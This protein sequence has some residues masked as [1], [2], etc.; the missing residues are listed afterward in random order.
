MIDVSKLWDAANNLRANSSLTAQ[1]YSRP[2]LGLL[3]LKFADHKYSNVEAEISNSLPANIQKLEYQ[4]KGVMY[5]PEES[6]YKYLINLPEGSDIGNKV[7]DAMR[8]IEQQN[9]DLKGILPKSYNKFESKMLFELLKT[10]NSIPMDVEGDVFGKI[11]EYFLG[12]FAM[13]EGQK[14]GD[15]F[16]PTS[17]VK[18]IVNI[19]EP[20]SGR[21]YDPACG[22]GGMFVQSANFV[23]RHQ[24]DI[25]D[26]SIFGQ[27]L[28][29][30]HVRIAKMNLAIHQLSGDVKQGNTYYDDEHQSLN[31]FDYV[32][33]NPPFNVS[34]VDKDRIKDDP[35]YKLGIP[36]ANNANYLWIQNF[37]TA[38]NEKGRAGFVIANSASDAGTSELEIRKKLLETGDVDIIIS[39]SSNFFYTVILPVTLWFFN[40][41]KSEQNNDKVLFID[42]REIYHQ[43]DRAHRDF[44]PEQLEFLA[45]IVRLYREGDIETT[46]GS[47]ELLNKHFSDNKYE[48]IKGLCK[49]ATLE[50]IKEQGYSLNPGRYVGVAEEEDD[51]VDFHERLGELNQE[52]D[53]LNEENRQFEKQIAKN[54]D[55]IINE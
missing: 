1:E 5:L 11:Y 39:I 44:K 20:Y 54:I 21:I 9:E 47:K 18:L 48:D 22:S 41:R 55:K 35:R 23:E 16:T 29:E 6:R 28:A 27:T 52:L 10:F 36:K 7:N 3:F 31:R 25:N 50:E 33:A 45:N 38:L 37:Y 2:V 15:F 26:I 14:G 12:K 42:A 30:D 46:L 49:V 19:I 13:S 8:M 43:I 53:S 32:M 51:G 24:G 4:A 17:I 40:K 34:G